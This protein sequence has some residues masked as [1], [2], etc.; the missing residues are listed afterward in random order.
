MVWV[1]RCGS[2]AAAPLLPECDPVVGAF[3]L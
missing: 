3:C 2:R 1:D